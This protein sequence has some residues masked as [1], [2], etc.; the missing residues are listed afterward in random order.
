MTWTDE[1]ENILSMADGDRSRENWS[2]GREV[3]CCICFLF[4]AI[5]SLRSGF[6][7]EFTLYAML[8]AFSA[9]VAR[10]LRFKQRS[11]SLVK[12]L[13]ESGGLTRSF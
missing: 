12:K 7:L 13:K 1:E 2:Y 8:F 11:L 5:W 9:E 3:V 4:L 10:L 6:S